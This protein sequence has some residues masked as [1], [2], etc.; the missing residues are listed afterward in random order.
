MEEKPVITCDIL[1]KDFLKPKLKRM[2][3]QEEKYDEF[4]CDFCQKIKKLERRFG[5]HYHTILA[6]DKA[7][8]FKPLTKDEY[9]QC[10]Y[11]AKCLELFGKH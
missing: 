11:D 7:C 2:S 3:E 9:S 1:F 8:N 5:V 4:R 10:C 6:Y